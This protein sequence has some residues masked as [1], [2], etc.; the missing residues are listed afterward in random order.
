MSAIPVSSIAMEPDRPAAL[1]EPSQQVTSANAGTDSNN[2][3]AGNGLPQD[4][5]QSGQLEKAVAAANDSMQ[6]WST[7]MRFDID[8]TSKRVVI[9]IIDTKTGKVLR[10]VP[11]D[12]VIRAAK[13][14]VKLQEKSIDTKA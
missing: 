9:S 8:P 10:T 5:S 1:P 11:T 13:M 2:A 4:P 3:T 6:A 12:A 14:I 7:G